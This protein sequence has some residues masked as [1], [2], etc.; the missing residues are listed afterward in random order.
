MQLQLRK[1]PEKNFP[2][3]SVFEPITSRYRCE[4]LT[5]WAMK[6]LMLGAGE[7]CVQLKKLLDVTLCVRLPTLLHVVGSCLAKFETASNISFVPWSPKL[8]ATKFHPFAQLFQHCWDH[9]RALH[10]VSKVLWVVSLPWCT[11][12]FKIVACCCI[13][14]HATDATTPKIAGRLHLALHS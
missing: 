6:P 3:S 1:K 11:T 8:S 4:A 13:R 12:G 9:A 2:T 10:L 7:L 14:L 5:N